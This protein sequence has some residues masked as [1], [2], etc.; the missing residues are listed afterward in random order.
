MNE[1]QYKFEIFLKKN[2]S[3]AR[4]HNC[5]QKKMCQIPIVRCFNKVFQFTKVV[6]F[7][8]LSCV[9]LLIDYFN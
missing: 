7:L 4:L 3:N 5:I 6:S 1:K 9:F 8:K 2:L